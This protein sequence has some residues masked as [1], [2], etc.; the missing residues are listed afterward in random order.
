MKGS[1]VVIPCSF[2]YPKNQHVKRVMWG[3]ERSN[4]INGPFIFDSEMKE[5]DTQFQYIGDKQHNCSFKIHDVEHNDTGKYTFRFI[6]D[7]AEGKW[8]GRVGST[9]KVVGKFSFSKTNYS[10]ESSLN[11]NVWHFK[12]VLCSSRF[13]WFDDETSWEQSNKGRRLCDSNLHKRLWR[14]SP[15]ICFHLV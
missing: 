9:L 6:T 12:A 3:H 2:Y 14:R 1:S 8:T 7:T 13:E 10:S 4:V 5:T 15:F 11:L